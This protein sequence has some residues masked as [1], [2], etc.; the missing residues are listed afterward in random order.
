MD[1]AAPQDGITNEEILAA[2]F[3]YKESGMIEWVLPTT[4]LGEE[5][6]VGWNGHILKFLTTEGVTG[7]LAGIAVCAAFVT[8][9]QDRRRVVLPA[10]TN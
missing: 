9:P 2:L 7:F 4:P 10:G 1:M 6:N 8:R 5:W 3:D